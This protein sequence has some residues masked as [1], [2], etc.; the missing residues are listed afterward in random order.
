VGSYSVACIYVH[1][2]RPTHIKLP[3][4]PLILY[5]NQIWPLV[6]VVFALFVLPKAHVWS[7]MSSVSSAVTARE[8]TLT[9]RS[10]SMVTT[11]VE[12]FKF[13]VW[14]LVPICAFARKSVKNI[15]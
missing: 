1:I 9:C 13:C 10:T 11:A 8:V 2:D 15:L 3:F 5:C 4:S 12:V 7:S 6:E 14:L